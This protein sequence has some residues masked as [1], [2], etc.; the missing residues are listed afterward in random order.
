[1]SKLIIKSSGEQFD[2]KDDACAN[3]THIPSLVSNVCAL[4]VDCT[5]VVKQANC[6]DSDNIHE[7]MMKS[8]VPNV[9]DVIKARGP[10]PTKSGKAE[11]LNNNDIDDTLRKL[12]LV[13]KGF[14]HVPF[15]MIDFA[16]LRSDD[17]WKVINGQTISPTELGTLDVLMIMKTHTSIGVVINTDARTGPGVH[18]FAIYISFDNPITIEYFNSSGNLPYPEIQEWMIKTQK[19]L[20]RNGHKAVIIR[21][22]N[23]VHQRSMSECGV[24]SLYFIWRRLN[25]TPY[26]VFNNK[27]VSDRTMLEFRSRLFVV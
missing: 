22:S 27:S 17:G 8:N 15:Q 23:V 14:Y 24:Y 18:W 16:G 11:W 5:D 10:V 21:P 3:V 26:S 19:L 13:H 20:E 12:T 4:D 7:C 2:C 25:G 9:R 1:M 6:G